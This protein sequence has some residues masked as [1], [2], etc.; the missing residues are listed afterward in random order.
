MKWDIFPL[1]LAVSS[2]ISVFVKCVYYLLA[3]SGHYVYVE[4]EL[5]DEAASAT[6]YMP[7][8]SNPHCLRFWYYVFGELTPFLT[9]GTQ[10]GDINEVYFTRNGTQ[11]DFW[12]P[13][14]I[15]LQLE[16]QS[17]NVCFREILQAM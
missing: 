14:T 11:G 10:K 9:A 6:L 17:Y 3:E 15:D 2:I 1:S 7:Q 13:A 4:A 8:I 12:H 5:E 16:G